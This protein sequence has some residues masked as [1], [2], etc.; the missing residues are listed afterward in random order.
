MTGPGRP[1]RED[2]ASLTLIAAEAL[3]WDYTKLLQEILKT[4]LP[5]R[6]LRE[7]QGLLKLTEE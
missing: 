1:G 2:Q 7:K 5:L 3:G 6:V 4:A